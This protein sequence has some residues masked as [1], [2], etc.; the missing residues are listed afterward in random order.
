MSGYLQHK[1]PQIQMPS[2]KKK[3][4]VAVKTQQ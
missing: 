3:K 1:K 4:K 2:K